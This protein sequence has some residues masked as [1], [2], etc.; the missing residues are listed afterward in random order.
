MNKKFKQR[1]KEIGNAKE[2]KKKL[3]Q[4]KEWYTIRAILGNA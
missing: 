2:L 1:A 4:N 3:Y